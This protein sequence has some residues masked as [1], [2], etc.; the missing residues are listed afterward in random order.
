MERYN[1]TTASI[2]DAQSKRQR[3]HVRPEVPNLSAGIPQNQNRIDILRIIS[4]SSIRSQFLHA[5]ERKSHA[6]QL[7]SKTEQFGQILRKIG[8]QLLFSLQIKATCTVK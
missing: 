8:I 4:N 7:N 6:V 3:K 2:R 1:C 5:I